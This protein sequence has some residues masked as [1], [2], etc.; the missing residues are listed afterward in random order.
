MTT[1][2]Y[3]D[4]SPH[5]GAPHADRTL[6]L[7]LARSRHYPSRQT[8]LDFGKTLC[9]VR[10]PER[11]IERIG[12]AMSD[13]LAEHRHRIEPGFFQRLKSEWD[14]GRAAVAPA[15]VHGGR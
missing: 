1:A 5:T 11:V 6:V 2:A 4:V 3:E 12:Q 15:M 10:S 14:S 8:L 13:T 9:H 7:K